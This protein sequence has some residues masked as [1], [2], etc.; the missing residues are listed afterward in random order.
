ME[1]LD[2]IYY[3][4]PDKPNK[5]SK[6]VGNI[7]KLEEAAFPQ[8]EA[9]VVIEIVHEVEYLDAEL[10]PSFFKN[11]VIY[12]V[13]EERDSNEVFSPAFQ[14]KVG[15]PYAFHRSCQDHTMIVYTTPSRVRYTR[16]KTSDVKVFPTPEAL[17]DGF[18]FY[19]NAY[20]EQKAQEHEGIAE[21][22]ASAKVYQKK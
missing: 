8:D 21:R 17:R 22:V 4:D 13:G 20:F 18:I 3:C 19:L 2:V 10:R 5:F 15:D 16:P 6:H 12:T 14:H 9:P 11:K 1:R 7:S